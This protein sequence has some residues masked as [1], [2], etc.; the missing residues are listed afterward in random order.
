M[1]T[2]QVMRR[3]ATSIRSEIPIAVAKSWAGGLPKVSQGIAP[4]S[5]ITRNCFSAPV[6]ERPQYQDDSW[7]PR[8]RIR[9]ATGRLDGVQLTELAQ[10]F[11][12]GSAANADT[13]L[14]GHPPIL[15]A[16][17]TRANL[18]LYPPSRVLRKVDRYLFSPVGTLL[19]LIRWAE[20]RRGRH[21][22]LISPLGPPSVSEP[23]RILRLAQVVK[24]TGLGS[25]AG[26]KC[27]VAGQEFRP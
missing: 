19:I 27:L 17:V 6:V 1:R 10:E 12:L 23:I 14:S 8:G 9:A 3:I 15:A 5:A 13:P 25:S 11:G 22:R 16:L 2:L 7:G 26:P 4:I 20:P 21:E 18:A 24:G